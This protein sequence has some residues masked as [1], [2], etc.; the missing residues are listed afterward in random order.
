VLVFAD[1]KA[2]GRVVP[3]CSALLGGVGS[4]VREQAPGCVA[5]LP[6]QDALAAALSAGSVATWGTAIV[7]E[8]PLHRPHDI[9]SVCSWLRAGA[10]QSVATVLVFADVKADG[11]V[12]S[13]CSALHGGVGS[14]VREQAP[15][16]V[17]QLLP[18]DAL[19]AVLADGSV[20]TW[21]TAIV[22]EAPLLRPH[23]V[24]SVCSWLRW[25]MR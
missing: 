19:A 2:D 22:E 23:D 16:C 4:A 15:G 12:V 21:G 6:P 18:Q 1:V 14:A 13:G 20:V 25:W 3:G 24:S 11:T 17:A 8:A 9:S 7:V 5:Q 10:L